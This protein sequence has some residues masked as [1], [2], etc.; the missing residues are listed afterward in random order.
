MPRSKVNRPVKS[1]KSKSLSTQVKILIAIVITSIL[2]LPL[3]FLRVQQSTEDRSQ[4]AAVVPGLKVVGTKLT[5]TDG[6]RFV[7][8]GVNM[9]YFR[10]NGCSYVTTN[11]ESQAAQI[12]AELKRIKVNAVRLNY[13]ADWLGQSGNFTKF[14]SFMKLLA[15]NGIYVMP[16]DHSFT[17][18][19]LTGYQTKSFPLFKQIV[20]AA[21]MDGFEDYLIMNPYNEPYGENESASTWSAW[22]TANKTTVEYIRKTLGFKGVIV[23]DTKDWA[24]NFDVPSM[25]T[26]IAYDATVNDGTANMVFA[27]HWYPNIPQSNIDNSIN[28]SDKVPVLIGE[29]G[30]YN[31][32][33][34]DPNYVKTAFNKVLTTGIPK[35]H[36]GIFPWIWA[37]CDDNNMTAAWDDFSHLNAF[38]QMIVDNYY[39]KV[40]NSST[41]LPA[42]S[43]SPTPVATVKPTPT[44]GA[45]P[46][47]STSDLKVTGTSL[48]LN[49]SRF[50]V[51]G[52]NVEYYRDAGCSY[53]TS[54]QTSQRTQMASK[55]KSLGINAVRLNY[56]QGW[57][58]ES[59][60]NVTNFLDMMQVLAQQGIYVMPTDHA[61]TGESLSGRSSAYPLF[62]QI[63]D[64]ARARGIEKYLIMNPYNEPGPQ[65][66]WSAWVTANKDTLNYIRN[67]AGFKGVVVLD[68]LSWSAAF[69]ANSQLAVRS[70]DATLLGGTPN[71][72]FS[73]HWYPNISIDSVNNTI[74][75]SGTVPVVIGEL[76]QINPGSSSLTPSYATNV[77]TNVINT[78]I[79][80]GHNGVF[81]W[82]WNW[83]DENGMTEDD[84]VTLNTFGNLVNNNYY[85]KVSGGATPTVTPTVIPSPIPSPTAKPASP[86]PLASMWPSPTVKP[87]SPAPSPKPSVTLVP[88]PVPSPSPSA[89]QSAVSLSIPI[90]EEWNNGYCAQIV[91]TNGTNKQI[92]NWSVS[93]NLNQSKITSKW[94]GRFV[95]VGSIVVVVPESWASWLPAKGRNDT[96]DFCATKTG[97]NWRPTQIGVLHLN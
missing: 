56:Y 27:N 53:I 24:A 17:G 57:M 97:N 95:Q 44:S 3:V 40:S 71:V 6:S 1:S 72:V 19:V 33:P 41:T 32:T 29:I 21:R 92:R 91:V 85:K 23:L 15:Q 79:P 20:D 52:V 36:N 81:A 84:F 87:A 58:N 66:S 67:T 96:L 55:M 42:S 18:D 4:A 73:N 74:N 34:L 47:P 9:E 37:W 22:I 13:S 59:P 8:S 14:R 7:I 75:N 2:L 39:S 94:G 5:A 86:T 88:S 65:D 62:K 61:Y 11:T 16:S 51:K 49:G 48:T 46:V 70:H 31:A 89:P 63:I 82:I 30:Q 78:G 80:K 50:I 38:G 35:G 25:Q 69:D 43:V 68:T 64:G 45:S 83:C 60:S 12:V 54:G 26:M 10:D 90:V 77:F 76:G 93:F 28:N